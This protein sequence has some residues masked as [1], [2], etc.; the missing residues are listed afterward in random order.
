MNV[1]ANP[2]PRTEFKKKP[3]KPYGKQFQH[4]SSENIEPS[5]NLFIH[6]LPQQFRQAD[7][8]KLCEPYGTILNAKV[9][10]DLQSG[11]S[12][13]F[14]FVLFQTL[15]QA[16][17]AMHAL[18]KKIIENKCLSVNYAQ[19]HEKKEQI[20]RT[21]YIRKISKLISQNDIFALFSQFGEITSFIPHSL[22]DNIEPDFWRC[23]IQYQTIESASNAIFTMNNQ[24][25]LS[26]SIPIYVHYADEDRMAN[27]LMRKMGV[28]PEVPPVQKQRSTIDPIQP[29]NDD[30]SRYLPSFLL[31]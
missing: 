5:P 11:E 22:D 9:M 24:V 6:Y 28:S 26:D 13:G 18:N 20:C 19:S 2:K 29:K 4:Y 14:G 7:L 1:V 27:T 15:E 10:V 3:P 12:R 23:F 16:T 31:S 17:N 8:I 21:I 30:E 25:I